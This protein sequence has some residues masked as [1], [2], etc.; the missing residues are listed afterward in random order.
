MTRER[1]T[2]SARGV[3]YLASPYSTGGGGTVFELKIQA[4]LLAVLLVHGYVPFFE[5]APIDELHLQAGHLGYETDDAHIVALDSNGRRRRQLW[6]IKHTVKFI[7]SDKDFRHVIEDAWADFSDGNRFDQDLD[8]IVLA[9]GRLATTYE[10]VLTLLESARASRS[11][12][13]FLTR[14]GVQGDVVARVPL[15]YLHLG[16]QLLPCAHLGQVII[17][18]S[19]FL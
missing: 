15:G 8:V 3:G 16:A 10:H 12:Q 5:S 18:D 1:K 6:A 4:G 7:E 14:I 19:G 9:T 17:S 13:D 2:D 11:A